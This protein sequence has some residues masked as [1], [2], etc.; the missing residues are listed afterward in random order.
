MAVYYSPDIL[1]AARALTD[2]PA[3]DF[4]AKAKVSRPALRNAETG[5]KHVTLETIERI[6]RAYEELGVEFTLP[7]PDHGA[8]VRWRTP[9]AKS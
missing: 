5:E 3:A 4:A 7:G 8:G 6:Q 1:R 9:Q 2:L